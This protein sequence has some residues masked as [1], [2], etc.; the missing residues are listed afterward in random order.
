MEKEVSFALFV[1]INKGRLGILN[2]K[3]TG[4]IYHMPLNQ[5]PILIK[6]LI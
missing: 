5:L 6:I 3:C 2:P 1:A 4:G